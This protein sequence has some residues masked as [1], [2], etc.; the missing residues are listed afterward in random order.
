MN[1]Q[2][3]DQ[4]NKDY[5]S[6]TYNKLFIVLVSKLNAKNYK[7]IKNGLDLIF[8]T[9]LVF[10]KIDYSSSF[11]DLLPPFLRFLKRDKSN[12]KREGLFNISLNLGP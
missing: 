6:D 12:C 10:M 5:K 1:L 3:K 9:Y 8:S 2:K 11:D 4:K 7:C